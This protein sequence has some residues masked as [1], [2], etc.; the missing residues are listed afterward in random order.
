MNYGASP[1]AFKKHPCSARHE[2]GQQLLLKELPGSVWNNTSSLA[3]VQ[4]FSK[5]IRVER[6]ILFWELLRRF[7][8]DN[9][10]AN[11]LRVNNLA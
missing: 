9:P 11:S 6:R 1:N 7:R 3:V 8:N 10:G 2:R 4:Y 5:K